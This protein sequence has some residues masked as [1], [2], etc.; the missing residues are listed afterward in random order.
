MTTRHK[1]FRPL[2][3]KILE[4]CPPSAPAMPYVQM[5]KTTAP[6]SPYPSGPYTKVTWDTEIYNTE[7][8]F[9]SNKFTPKHADTYQI[10]TRLHLSTDTGTHTI[11]LALYKNG[12][13]SQS[14]WNTHTGTT[15]A[16]VSASFTITPNGTTD[17]YEIYVQHTGA[18]SFTLYSSYGKSIFTAAINP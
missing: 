8:E 5:I 13:L 17:Y 11:V 7:N 6:E 9:A 12:T 2:A 16:H 14:D 15:R 1:L 4:A 3:S 18:T 10:L